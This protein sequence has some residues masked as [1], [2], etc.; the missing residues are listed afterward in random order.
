MFI[1]LLFI[2]QNSL[3]MSCFIVIVESIKSLTEMNFE[4]I[5]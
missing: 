5:M 4:K 2:L 1:R 3:T